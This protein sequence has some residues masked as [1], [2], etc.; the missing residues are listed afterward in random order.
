[1]QRDGIYEA[2]RETRD[3]QPGDHT[4]L[5]YES[6]EDLHAVMVSYVRAG[7]ERNQR[8]FYIADRS[9]VEPILA[10]LRR[11]D[12]LQLQSRID[13]GQLCLH[14]AREVYV[15]DGRFDPDAM[16]E[17][18][19]DETER[20]TG[21]GYDALRITGDMS[22]ALSDVAGAELLLEYEVRL[23]EFYPGSDAFTIC[24]YDTRRFPPEMILGVLQAHPTVI[25]GREFCPNSYYMPPEELYSSHNETYRLQRWLGNIRELQNERRT[26]ARRERELREAV[27]QKEQLLREL[28]H[29]VKNSL[30]MVSSLMSLKERTSPAAQDLSEVKTFVNTIQLIHDKLYRVDGAEQVSFA[31]YL[32][33]LLG[34][35]VSLYSG[36]P[37]AVDIDVPDVAL[38]TSSAVNIGLI[39]NELTTN[40]LKHGFHR[41]SEPRIEVTLTWN[42]GSGDYELRF[43]NNGSAL[44]DEFDLENPATEGL[45][46]RLVKS[47]VDK[48]DGTIQVSRS[49]HP[50]FMIHF[51]PE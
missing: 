26:R 34:D 11:D 38:P 2:V 13:S 35:V 31:P 3:M 40:T 8:V 48:I 20:A 37:V 6:D 36:P 17:L 47:F 39:L 28:N 41:V 14:T 10:E 23:N 4:S 27:D 49:P 30:L 18:L 51:A 44:P 21:D 25:I 24:Q 9:A 29:R 32:R 19:S 42:D 22:W 12:T 50:V 46:T 45:G 7:L 16:I 5:I 33:E 15:R 1:M 43:S